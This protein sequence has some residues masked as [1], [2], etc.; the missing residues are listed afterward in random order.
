MR[1]KTNLG[2][3]LAKI[4]NLRPKI[5]QM[6]LLSLNI[7]GHNSV[8]FIRFDAFYF[9]LLVFSKSKNKG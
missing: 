3:K 4:A 9:K 2:L 1:G 6:Q 7:N 8:I 5:G